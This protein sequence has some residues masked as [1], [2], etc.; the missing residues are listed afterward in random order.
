MNG[1]VPRRSIGSNLDSDRW[2]ILVEGRLAG[3]G[4]LQPLNEDV[5]IALVLLPEFW[6][7]GG[8]I[9]LLLKQ[10]AFEEVG[11]PHV[12]AAVPPTRGE[13][14]GFFDWVS[15]SSRPLTS[16]VTDSSSTG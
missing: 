12:L 15:A 6:G 9:F 11:L 5:E 3:W 7:W 2:G 10:Y 14:R 1:C 13:G 4:G 16:R 8:V